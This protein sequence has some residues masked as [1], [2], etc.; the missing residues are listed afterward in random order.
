MSPMIR[1]R[2]L[3]ER[4][5]LSHEKAAEQMGISSAAVWAIESFEDDLPGCYSPNDLR[6]FCG[7]LGC[8]SRELFDV[9]TTEPPVSAEALVDLIHEQCR[10]RG[11]TLEQFEDVVGWRLGAMMEPPELLLKDMSI[12]G[13]QA[14]CQELGIHWHRLIVGL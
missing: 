9:E 2:E 1:F 14:L 7:V 10:S 13:L 3:R 12:D 8:Q 6:K 11:I 4:A 5:G